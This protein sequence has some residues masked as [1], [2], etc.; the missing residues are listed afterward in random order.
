M[1]GKTAAATKVI[2]ITGQTAPR[3]LVMTLR[4][5][6]MGK[7]LVTMNDCMPGISGWVP[8]KWKT[9]GIPKQ[10]VAAVAKR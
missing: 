4:Y 6:A 8:K 3:C 7:P 9:L 2:Q 1:A 10:I 5:H